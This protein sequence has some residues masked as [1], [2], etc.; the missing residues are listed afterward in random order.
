MRKNAPIGTS[1]TVNFLNDAPAKI[2]QTRASLPD[3]KST[4]DYCIEWDDGDQVREWG[5]AAH[6][7]SEV[8]S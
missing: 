2:T 6:E 5:V 1:V 8:A 4:F 7:I 3:M